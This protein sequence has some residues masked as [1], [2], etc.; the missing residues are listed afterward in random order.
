V[1]VHSTLT[2]KFKSQYE[3]G[4]KARSAREK[5]KGDDKEGE[6]N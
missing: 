3:V 6:A 5:A 2:T 4:Q 1:F